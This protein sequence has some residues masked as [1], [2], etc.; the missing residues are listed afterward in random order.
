MTLVMLTDNN[1]GSADATVQFA[2]DDHR[3]S[4]I[5][6]G[7]MAIVEYEETL[8]WRGVIRVSEPD[9]AVYKELMSSEEVTKFLNKYDLSS[10]RRAR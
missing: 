1:D 7:D 10:I 8:S 6:D 3:F 2:D 4:L 9:E 5:I